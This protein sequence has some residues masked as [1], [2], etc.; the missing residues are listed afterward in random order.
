MEKQILNHC[1]NTG[2]KL[3]PIVVICLTLAACGGSADP[4]DPPNATMSTALRA[5]RDRIAPSVSITS[6]TADAA[7][8]SEQD[9]VVLA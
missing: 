5:S 8:T 9:L 7:L 4:Q 3:T 1:L 2:I 6:P